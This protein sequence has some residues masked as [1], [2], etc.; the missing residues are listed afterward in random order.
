MQ[1]KYKFFLFFVLLVSFMVPVQATHIVGGEM[2][3]RCLGGDLYEVSLTVFRD[4]DAG[5]APFDAPGTVGVYNGTTNAYVFQFQMA[6]PDDDTIPVFAPDTC[7]TV[8]RNVC[9]HT[10][11]YRDTVTLPYIADGYTLAYQRC[12]RNNIISNINDPGDTGATYSIYISGPALLACN[13]NAVFTDFPRIYLC[14]GVQISFDHSAVD[15]D[16]DSIVYEMC[17]PYGGARPSNPAPLPP[18]TAPVYPDVIWNTQA[19]YSV[20]NQLGGND[21]LRIDP[22]TG[23]L[24]G[25]PPNQGVFLVGICAK[26]YRNGVL[27]SITRRDFQHVIGICDRFVVADFDTVANPCS[28]DLQYNFTN[29]SIISSSYGTYEWQIDTFLTTTTNNPSFTFPDTG[30]YDITILAGIGSPCVDSFTQTIDV[31]LRAID[32]SVPTPPLACEG[33]RITLNSS[34]SFASTSGNVNY[35]WS[36]DS[37]LVQGQGLSSAV[38]ASND[39]ATVKVVAT[40]QYDCMDSVLVPLSI[41]NLIAAFDSTVAQCNTSLT[42]DFQNNTT[43]NIGTATYFWDFDGLGTSNSANPSFSFPDTGYY[44]V[45]MIAGAG[46]LCPDT[47]SQRV[48]LPLFGVDLSPLP[49]LELCPDE[50]V[51]VSISDS[52]ENYSNSII[53]NWSPASQIIAGQGTDSVLVKASAVATLQVIGTNNFSCIDTAS[54]ELFVQLITADF[55]T[56]TGGC[57]SSLIVTFSN[58]TSTNQAGLRYL[59]D[60]ASLATSIRN[61]PIYTFSDTGQYAITLIAGTTSRCPDTTQKIIDIRNYGIDIAGKGGAVACEGDTLQLTASNRL[62]GFTDTTIYNWSPASQIIAGQGTDTVLAVISQ[63]TT[64]SIEGTNSYNCKDIV[65]VQTRAQAPIPTP[66][67]SVAPDSIYAGQSAQI[68]VTGEPDYVYRWRKDVTLSSLTSSQPIASPRATTWYYLFTQNPFGCVDVDSVL[69]KIIPPTCAAPVVFMPNAFSPDGDG[70]NDVLRLAGN[71]IERM[72]MIIYN[73]WGQKVFETT[74]Q[75]LGWDGTFQGK[76]LPPD[77]YGYY[78]ECECVDGTSMTKRGNVTLLK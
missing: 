30:K 8:P 33:E 3:Y 64:F 55:D 29:Q 26:E 11:T 60:F 61:N 73:R 25:T 76:A 41:E 67:V 62:F 40:N 23:R 5:Q 58:T 36:P 38:F 37:L 10:V 78:L 72:R 12:C 42:I 32:I 77:V 44:Q 69:V 13:S 74:T 75:R 6:L 47:L 31:K 35:V 28:R 22:V 50:E 49:D 65:T 14:Q 56:T 68:Q 48:Y 1:N 9:V 57:D 53:Y 54:S 43:T 7:L 19:G 18:N 59:W 21:P 52:L 20:N 15:P 71:N 70:R 45:T 66:Q 24:T 51:W 16:G 46:S 2:N 34:N 27:M 63:N 17:T 39:N 4:C